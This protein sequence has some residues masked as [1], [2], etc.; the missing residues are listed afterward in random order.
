M[1]KKKKNRF[2]EALTYYNVIIFIVA[3][4]LLFAS[5]DIA[6]SYI[7]STLNVRKEATRQLVQ[8]GVYIS[9]ACAWLYFF[10]KNYQKKKYQ[11]VTG[12][13]LDTDIAKYKRSPS[14]LLEYFKDADPHKLDT[15]VFEAEHWSDAN[16]FIFGM[17]KN[18]LVKI[19]SASESNIAVFGP[20]GTGK[21]AGLANINAITF[22]GSVLA[23]DIKGDIYA[24]V[25]KHSDREIRLFCPEDPENSAHF[26]PLAGLS[27]MDSTYKK[28]Y[29]ESMS[30]ILIADEGGGG[31]DGNYF[32][33]RARKYYQGICHM[34]YYENP[35]I[36]FP[37]IVHKILEGNAF[38]W[39][40]NAI[41]G[42]C[43]EAK[44]LLSSFFGNNEK[45]VTGAYDNLVTAMTPF[46]NEALDELLKD[47]GHCISSNDLEEGRD[48]YL[49]I[50]QE[51][52][53]AYAPLF[54]LI[55]QA[56]STAF[57][58]RPDNSS[59]IKTRPVLMLLDEFPAL[60][61]SYKLINS[62]LSTL[63]SKNIVIVMIQ[64]NLAQL[65]KRYDPTGARS[66][67]GNCNYQIILGSNDIA[68][69]KVFSDTFGKR[70]ILKRSN[71][72]SHSQNETTSWSVQEADE[73]IFRPEDFGYLGTNA[74]LYFKGKYAMI[75]K[76]N[77]Y[78]DVK[79]EM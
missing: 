65:E 44:E 5:K 12:R 77:C 22:E 19:P 79:P 2:L 64:Q 20:P 72:E 67:V 26:N 8:Y 56:F 18:K 10:Y 73:Q 4:L 17:A 45:N 28:L 3:A 69:S 41:N 48:V 37:E 42:E 32:V 66:L 1:V 52:L 58:K 74:V 75:R 54:T 63:R 49:Q 11:K 13:N 7:C 53:D 61:Y 15:S 43:Q 59:G 47:D 51:H 31:S 21:T 25:S 29:I 14:Q 24:Y 68:S 40:N 27:E 30:T 23:I 62:N 60:T 76:L 33:T 36:T 57:T 16:G 38:D 35:D 34:L 78:R 55:V 6:I 39:V 9:E 50:K 71:S 46:A 70:R